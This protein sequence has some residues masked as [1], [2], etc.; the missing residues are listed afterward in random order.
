MRIR[1]MV[2]CSLLTA[3]ASAYSAE[4]PR[5]IGL[6]KVATGDAVILRTSQRIIAKPGYQIY[7]KDTLSTGP[8][9][10]ISVILRDDTVLALGSSS[11]IHIDRFAFEPSSQ[12]LGMVLR[13]TRGIIGYRSGRIA[14]LAPDA[15]RIETP[16]ATMGIRGTYLMMRIVP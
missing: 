5:P 9:G 14:K 15:V 11:E 6:I 12:D 4:E 7:Q 13:V 3:T 10:A 1:L 2:I 8:T 16:K